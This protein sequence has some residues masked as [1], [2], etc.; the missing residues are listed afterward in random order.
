[1]DLVAS[2]SVVD[3]C[4]SSPHPLLP[5]VEGGGTKVATNAHK[6]SNLSLI[7]TMITAN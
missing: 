6:K 3:D 1:M 4:N 2:S 5:S 7:K